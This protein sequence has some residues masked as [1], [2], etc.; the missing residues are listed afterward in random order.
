MNAGRGLAA[1]GLS[2]HVSFDA[3]ASLPAARTG[4]SRRR[5]RTLR[6]LV[7]GGRFLSALARPL[8]DLE[9]A[10]VDGGESALD[11]LGAGNTSVLDGAVDRDEIADTDIPSGL[12]GLA[13]Q[14]D[15]VPVL[16]V[17]AILGRGGPDAEDGH[18]GA[19]VESLP[20]GA[21]NNTYN[22]SLVL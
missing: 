21:P 12:G 18:G 2:S 10:A 3:L 11:V 16:P 4:R 13:P 19:T 8:E 14:R 17:L 22:A 9:L 5:R 1:P 6:S 20:L 7:A 15:A